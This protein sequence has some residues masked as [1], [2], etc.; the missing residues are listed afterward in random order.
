MIQQELAEANSSCAESAECSCRAR[1]R[2]FGKGGTSVT[3]NEAVVGKEYVIE[4]VHTEDAEMDA[5][6]FSLGC[7]SGEPITVIAHRAGGPIVAIKDSR[8]SIDRS[9]ASAIVV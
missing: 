4:S 1:H 8:Y 7:Y 6:L 9:L 5:F 3:L 2:E